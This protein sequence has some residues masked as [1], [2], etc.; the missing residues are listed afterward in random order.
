MRAQ[1]AGDEAKSAD[2]EDQHDEGVEKTS[3]AKID[4][5]VGEHARENE[6]R[7]CKSENPAGCAATVPEEQTH[8][9]KHGDQGD[10]ESVRAEKAPKG[11]D[12]ADLIGQEVAPRQLMMM[13]IRKWPRPPGVPPTS[14][15]E[16]FSIGGRIAEGSWAFSARFDD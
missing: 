12:N 1:G 11:T 16:R 4:V 15:K 10:A 6:E 9:E 5:H 8:A 7:T 14:L 2:K 13:P 3:G